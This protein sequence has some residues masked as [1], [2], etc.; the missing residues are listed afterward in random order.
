MQILV[1]HGREVLLVPQDTGWETEMVQPGP[2]PKRD[3]ADADEQ[4]RVVGP[5]PVMAQ[6]GL[7][8]THV[9]RFRR[10]LYSGV[11]TP[12]NSSRWRGRFSPTLAPASVTRTSLLAGR[13][14][15]EIR[16][17]GHGRA[18]RRV[19]R[20]VD[21]VVLLV[22]L[23]PVSIW[24]GDLLSQSHYGNSFVHAGVGA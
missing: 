9:T 18:R 4:H 3:R 2:H 24:L 10:R 21:F 6:E 12:G 17:A 16:E 20:A 8:N 13:T 1:G 15:G 11:S 23:R 14:G 7:H 5:R 19:E 22:G